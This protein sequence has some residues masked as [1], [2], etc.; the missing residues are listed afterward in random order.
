MI[1][2]TTWEIRH[3]DCLRELARLPEAARLI[4]ADPPYNQ[5]VDYGQGKQVDRLPREEY[6]AWCRE[7]IRLSA[8]ALTDDGSLWI[9]AP[10]EWVAYVAIMLDQ[11]GLHRRS[12]IKWYETFGVN[13]TRK[14]NRC[15]RHILHYVAHPKRFVFN[16][17]AVCRP[18]DRQ[19]KYNDRR[20]KAGG[21]VWDDVWIIPRLAG[22]HRERIPGF[23][24]QLP[25]RLLRPIVGCASDP[26]DL[27]VDPF[28]GSA[29]TG[30]AALE[31][32]RRYIGIEQSR[33]YCKLSRQRLRECRRRPAGT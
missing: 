30:T 8:E 24:T 9:V 19:R 32:G 12:W 23:P 5:G 28:S 17:E 10:D 7:W 1:A 18:S 22:T 13:C 14:F 4:V 27:V 21:K 2:A 25:L 29:T 16:R 20:A 33:H 31:L 6:L 11:A 26:G 3:G 15:S